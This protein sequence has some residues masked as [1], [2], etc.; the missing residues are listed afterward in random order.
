[1]E[2]PR[3][4]TAR[5]SFDPVSNRS[6]LSHSPRKKTWLSRPA[7]QKDCRAPRNGV[8][9]A[10]A[11]CSTRPVWGRVQTA[12]ALFDSTRPEVRHPLVLRSAPSGA[13]V[14]G[15]LLRPGGL[16]TR[17]RA[18]RFRAGRSRNREGGGLRRWG[19][20]SSESRSGGR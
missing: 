5:T 2:L 8:S 16:E 13:S 14:G 7:T 11:R 3:S 12:S 20:S 17:F 1:M 6:A 10:V 15:H 4:P 19:L 9:S 18:P